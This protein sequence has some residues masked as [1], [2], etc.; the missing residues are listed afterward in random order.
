MKKYGLC[1]LLFFLG[2]MI[3]QLSLIAGGEDS[4]IR[5]VAKFTQVLTLNLSTQTPREKAR[6]N[7]LMTTIHGQIPDI[8]RE[9]IKAE[10]VSK[11]FIAVNAS[12]EDTEKR[13]LKCFSASASG[14]E[15][16]FEAPSL[17]S[18]KTQSLNTPECAALKEKVR[19]TKGIKGEIDVF[20]VL[21]YFQ[22]FR[23]TCRASAAA[24]E[25]EA[26]QC[27]LAEEDERELCTA[28]KGDS[29]RHLAGLDRP[30]TES[31]LTHLFNAEKEKC[32][33]STNRMLRC[34]PITKTGYVQ[35]STPECLR[36]KER[37]KNLDISEPESE[38]DAFT[39]LKHFQ[40]SIDG[41]VKKAAAIEKETK[42]C[43]NKEWANPGKV[44]W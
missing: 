36:I 29:R 13:A 6:C 23:E 18:G 17:E 35:I 28:R 30:I 10:H 14:D 19:S 20:E 40:G 11:V 15:Q 8:K 33:I 3:F 26:Y 2:A 9:N 25:K 7:A 21:D 42:D 4:K 12:C 24:N 5:S 44:S 38:R 43:F 41:C 34:F 1:N 39:I 37:L 32:A 22:K 16:P 27:L 31:D